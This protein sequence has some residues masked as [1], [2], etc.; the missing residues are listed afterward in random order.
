MEGGGGR[1]RG[2]GEVVAGGGGGGGGLEEKRGSKISKMCMHYQARPCIPT[3]RG[4]P[5]LYK[6]P[7]LL[8]L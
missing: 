3:L 1:G 5:T 8:S 7:L 4:R 2:G 6:S